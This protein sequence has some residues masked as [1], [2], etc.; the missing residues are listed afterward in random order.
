MNIVL[1][2]P[3]WGRKL[4]ETFV[5]FQI[6]VQPFSNQHHSLYFK[7]TPPI[8]YFQNYFTSLEPLLFEVIWECRLTEGYTESSK[9]FERK[10]FGVFLII[11]NHW[12]FKKYPREF[13]DWTITGCLYLK[14]PSEKFVHKKTDEWY[15]EWQ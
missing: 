9:G 12:S 5:P 4:I 15:I 14:P 7:E 3:S 6:F 1:Y 10:P 2:C 13:T 11:K 8:F